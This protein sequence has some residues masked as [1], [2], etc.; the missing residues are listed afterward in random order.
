MTFTV[1]DATVAPFVAG[2]TNMRAWLDKAADAEATLIGARLAADMH[3]LPFQYQTASDTAK[4][5][6]ARLAG[7]E[8]PTMADTEASFAELKDR[9]ARTVDFIQ[10]VDP[11]A[12]AGSEQ[13]EVELRFRNGMG[14]RLAGA[15]FLTGFAL[16]NFYFHMTTAYA[17]MRQAGVPLGKPDFL[18]HLGPPNLAPGA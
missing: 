4:N 11:A 17:I 1:Q 14:Y 16:P 15:A 6:I 18:R 2:L 9:C 3:P 5:A 12:L 10:G 13:R 8:A 7:I